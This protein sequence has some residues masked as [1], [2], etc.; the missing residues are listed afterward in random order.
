M[1]TD[2]RSVNQRSESL[3]SHLLDQISIFFKYFESIEF[4]QFRATIMSLKVY[5]VVNAYVLIRAK[6]DDDRREISQSAQ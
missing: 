6:E 4:S 2:E 1:M 3:Q 5:Q